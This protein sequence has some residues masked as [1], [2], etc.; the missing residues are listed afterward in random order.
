MEI[1]QHLGVLL[2]YRMPEEIK[3]HLT[4][5]EIYVHVWDALMRVQDVLPRAFMYYGEMECGGQKA[6]PGNLESFFR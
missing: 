1:G 3:E 6:L 5:A 4:D 2:L